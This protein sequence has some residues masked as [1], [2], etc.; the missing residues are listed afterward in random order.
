MLSDSHCHLQLLENP[1]EKVKRAVDSGIEYIIC[2]GIGGIKGNEKAIELAERFRNVYATCGIHPTEKEKDSTEVLKY[3]EEVSYHPRVIGIGETGIDLQNNK[4][5]KRQIELF[6]FHIDL[7]KKTGKPLI[8]H[9]RGSDGNSSAFDLAIEEI[10]GKNVKGVFHCFSWGK[11]E[12]LQAKNLGFFISYAGN[13]TY[14]KKIAETV[15]STPFD[16]AL[17]ETDAPFLTPEQER[18][19][20]NEP[21]FLVHTAKKVAELKGIFLEDVFRT[22]KANLWRVFNLG[23]NPSYRFTYKIRNSLY[24]NLTIRCT[25]LCVFCGKFENFF[26]RG[27]NLKIP[28]EPSVEEVMSEIGDPT[29]YDEIVFCGYG[30]PTLRLDELKRISKELKSKGAKRIR[31]DTDGLANLVHN[32]NILP[33]LAGLI[34]SISVS[35]NAPDEETYEKLCPS[36]YGRSAYKYVKDFIAQSKKFIPDVKATAVSHPLVDIE[37]TR[38]VVEKELGVP[39]KVRD[40]GELG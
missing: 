25:I 16:F 15:K 40:Y 26:I 19:K 29:V 20:L 21:S 38:I 1:N 9:T 3:I 36:K 18:G 12:A 11:R 4:E 35:I 8:V 30:E 32:R 39:F 33:E 34:D 37:K 28:N 22:V 24:I 27:H 6:R 7:S 5:L 14:K 31:L 10:K 17:L 23:E 2:V 13:I